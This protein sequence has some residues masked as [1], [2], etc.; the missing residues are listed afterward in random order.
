MAIIYGNAERAKARTVK[1]L[2]KLLECC[3][4]HPSAAEDI[5]EEKVQR[6]EDETLGSLERLTA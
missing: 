2:A 3:G 6:I 1:E 5:A 4:V